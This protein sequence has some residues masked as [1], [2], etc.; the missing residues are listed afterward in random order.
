MND[1]L[2]VV[3][4]RPDGMVTKTMS[5]RPWYTYLDAL[6][7]HDEY[8]QM[9]PGTG[10]W[11]NEPDEATWQEYVGYLCW[12]RRP[13]GTW[14]AYCTVPRTHPWFGLNYDAEL[15]GSTTPEETIQVHG[16][17]TFAGTWFS[18]GDWWFGFDTAH[19]WDISPTSPVMTG[20]V[21]RD[22]DYVINETRSLA[23][24]LKEKAK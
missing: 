4:K 22:M 11:I 10:P 8:L 23:K 19:A 12:M 20:A 18:E 15:P 9:L 13:W 7:A 3:P 21:Y 1:E 2:D 24:Q 17:L 14:N 16:G 5:P 6:N